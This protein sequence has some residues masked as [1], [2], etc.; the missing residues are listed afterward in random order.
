MPR[1]PRLPCRHHGCPNL[2]DAPYCE[3]H[4]I[5]QPKRE[6]AAVRGYNA[7]WRIARLRFL[8]NNP[9][10]AECLRQGRITPAT[11]VDHIIPHRGDV[12]LFWNEQNWQSLCKC[13]HDQKT[14]K[15]L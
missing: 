13:C 1:K 3:L 14:A 6:S 5:S 7:S 15:G 12:N 9:L 2:S 11:V 10:C 8:R 4:R